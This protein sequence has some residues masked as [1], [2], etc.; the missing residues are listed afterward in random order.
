V[1]AWPP[2]ELP[3]LHVDF[4]EWVRGAGRWA[5]RPS[6]HYRCICGFVRTAAGAKDVA[7]LTS[8]VPPAHR[9]ACPRH[10]ARQAAA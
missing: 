2:A 10:R 7:L 5:R 6:A 4:G 8:S 1:S 9:A 3:G